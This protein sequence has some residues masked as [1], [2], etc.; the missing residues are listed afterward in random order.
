MEWLKY[1]N[2]P[3][4]LHSGDKSHWL[5]DADVLFNSPNIREEI[6]TFWASRI[7]N[8]PVVIHSIPTGGDKWAN[9]LQEKLNNR[10]TQGNEKWIIIIDDVITT[11]KSIEEKYNSL[12]SG[13]HSALVVVDRRIIKYKNIVSVGCWMRINLL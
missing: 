10:I 6:L 2:E 12:E 9:A 11:G 4:K 13:A 8:W 3:I 5:V 7:P 1:F